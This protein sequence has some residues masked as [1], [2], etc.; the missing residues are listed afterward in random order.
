MVEEKKKTKRKSHIYLMKSQ[1]MS[2]FPSCFSHTQTWNEAAR[3]WAAC[4]GRN[5]L[6]LGKWEIPRP[7]GGL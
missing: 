6:H 4:S 2:N 7:N 1:E 5:L 3:L